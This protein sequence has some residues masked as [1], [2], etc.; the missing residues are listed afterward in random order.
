MATN[1]NGGT[2][3]SF[4]NTPQA[5][6]DNFTS[7]ITFLTEDST[8]VVYLNVMSNDLGGNAKV[9]WSLDNGINNSGVM[10]GYIAGDLLTQD[11]GRVEA[12]SSDTS[13]NGAR[14]WITSDGKVGY[15]AGTLSAS[16]RLQLQML[17]VGQ[18]LTDTFIYAIRL[19]NGTLSWATATVH[20]L[21]TNDGPTISAAVTS[22]QVTE[23]A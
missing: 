4:T 7:D 2:T 22:G 5:K 8:N 23:R 14:I 15:D 18:D 3:A 12:T 21:G 9:L 11:T 13:S 10:N 17:G 16:F 6:D 19:A 20:F 1:T